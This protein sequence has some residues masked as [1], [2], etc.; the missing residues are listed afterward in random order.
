ML[1]FWFALHCPVLYSIFKRTKNKQWKRD[2]YPGCVFYMGQQILD[3]RHYINIFMPNKISYYVP[4]L[5]TIHIYLLT[6]KQVKKLS[7]NT[8]CMF[9]MYPLVLVE[10]YCQHAVII[11]SALR[12]CV[13]Y[14]FKDRCSTCIQDN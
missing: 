12:E 14:M 5:S 6:I 13:L 4:L 7:S 2:W 11:R 1:Y 3:G 10:L 8:Y 9:R